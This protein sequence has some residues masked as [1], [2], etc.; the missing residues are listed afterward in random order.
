MQQHI[1]CVRNRMH[2]GLNNPYITTYIGR[3]EADLPKGATSKMKPINKPKSLFTK[4]SNA[5]RTLKRRRMKKN[6]SSSSL[7][8]ITYR[9][10]VGVVLR[11]VLADGWES[12]SQVSEMP[13][14]C[15][16]AF[17]TRSREV[18]I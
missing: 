9:Q 5:I 14:N 12:R 1:T 8:R 7:T 13:R 16:G 2:T 4:I 3:H 17:G 6:P 18:K 15:R 10:P 11:Q